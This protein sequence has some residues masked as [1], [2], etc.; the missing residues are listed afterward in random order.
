MLTGNGEFREPQDVLSEIPAPAPELLGP[1]AR[2]LSFGLHD[3]VDVRS[4]VET[5]M[6]GGRFASHC[7]DDVV[8][9]VNEVATNAVEH[10][11][12]PARIDVWS[13]PAGCVVEVHD[14]GVLTDPLPGLRPPHP[15]QRR[16]WGM[17]VVRQACDYVH[18]W[19]D[20]RGTHLRMHVRPDR[21]A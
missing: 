4:M 15:A 5:A 10:G 12:A 21:L 2:R 16:G 17:W 19:G 9:A 1:P 13:D 3:L 6:R 20:D 18:V 11:T 7:I 8:V 14:S